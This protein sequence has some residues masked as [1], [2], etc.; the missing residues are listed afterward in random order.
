MKLSSQQPLAIMKINFSLILLVGFG[1]VVLCQNGDANEN[2]SP[3][4]DSPVQIELE[5]SKTLTHVAEPIELA[6]TVT[7]PAGI[8][9]QLPTLE[10]HIGPFDV[11]GHRDINDIPFQNSR[12]WQRKIQLESLTAGELEIPTIEI[13]Y[14]DRRND[15]LKTGIASTEPKLISVVSNFETPTSPKQFRDIQSVV[16]IQENETPIKTPLTASTLIASLLL[17]LGFAALVIAKRKKD[18]P[19]RQQI[20]I[21]LDNLQTQAMQKLIGDDE[22]LVRLSKIARDFSKNEYQISAPELTTNEF[23]FRTRSDPRLNLKLKQLLS[24]L[25]NQ[26]DMIKFA[27]AQGDGVDLQTS[28]Q[29]L[30]AIVKQQGHNQPRPDL[31]PR[32]PSQPNYPSPNMEAK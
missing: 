18:I 13:G 31:N 11:I 24:N 10:D 23:L 2:Q 27:G 4:F 9:V 5:F 20:L 12:Q 8:T 7:A 17:A 19:A 29:Q 26:A 22:A 1:L 32:S 6:I 30:T 14:T 21:R 16:F 15:L 25:L 28:I 3:P